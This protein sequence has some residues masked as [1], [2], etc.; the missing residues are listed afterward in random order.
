MVDVIVSSG[1]RET[2]N[3]GASGS[4]LFCSVS[5]SR[6]N[7]NIRVAGP[8]SRPLCFVT[9]FNKRG[10]ENLGGT[11][12]LHTITYNL[13]D[14][15]ESTLYTKQKKYRGHLPLHS[16]WPVKC[17][18]CT[19]HLLRATAAEFYRR[20]L[21]ECRAMSYPSKAYPYYPLRSTFST[22]SLQHPL[23]LILHLTGVTN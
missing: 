10:G 7:K 5:F 19:L 6:F 21:I 22:E 15:S 11:T 18:G 9:S 17:Y 14:R 13:G 1:D 4:T 23:L 3:R 12:V 2:V 8:G 20:T 16:P